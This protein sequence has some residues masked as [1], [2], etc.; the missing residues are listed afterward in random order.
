AFAHVLTGPNNHTSFTLP[1]FPRSSFENLLANPSTGDETLVMANSDGGITG[2]TLN[3]VEAYVGTKQYTGNE[4]QRA[5]LTNGTTYQVAVNGVTAESRNFALGTSS[6]VTA[7]TFT[8]V[9]GFG[10]TTFSRPED[11]AWDPR[12]PYDY[13]FVTTDVLDTVR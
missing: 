9:N 6:L 5:G 11:G 1:A 2:Q 8:L 7:G 12:N 4:V 3:K 13:Y 10:G